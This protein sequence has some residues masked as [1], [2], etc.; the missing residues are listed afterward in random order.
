MSSVPGHLKAVWHPELTKNGFLKGNIV[1]P[2][3]GEVF[4]V[5]DNENSPSRGYGEDGLLIQ[6][7]CVQ[8]G[9]V[10]VIVDEAKHGYDGFVC[11]SYQT[12][13]PG[14]LHPHLCGCGSSQFR[15]TV[16]IEPEDEEQF[17]EEVVA[18]EPDSFQPEDFVNAFSWITIDTQCA[19]CGVQ[20]NWIDLETA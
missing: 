2:C 1:C 14:T 12:A 10:C 15:M 6:A 11:H 16:S 4:H 20:E 8:C 9:A 7:T 13:D 19:D 5:S 17:M 3:G 18:E